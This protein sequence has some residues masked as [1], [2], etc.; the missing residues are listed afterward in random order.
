MTTTAAA[1]RS[2]GDGCAGD[3]GDGT[4]PKSGGLASVKQAEA[5]GSKRVERERLCGSR[6]RRRR[7]GLFRRA[8]SGVRSGGKRGKTGV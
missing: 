6:R 5:K 8:A 7:L 1:A 2:V 4:A 3:D